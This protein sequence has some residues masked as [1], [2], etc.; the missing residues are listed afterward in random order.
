M[1]TLTPGQVAALNRR[2]AQAFAR[3]LQEAARETER[4]LRVTATALR[5]GPVRPVGRGTPVALSKRDLRA[6]WETVSFAPLDERS[7][8]LF[9][10]SPQASVLHGADPTSRSPIVATIYAAEGGP[11]LARMA[12]ALRRAMQTP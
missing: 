12:T 3:N 7:I 6:S 1:A 2:R 9:N 11:F 10:R 5:S 8:A 4:S